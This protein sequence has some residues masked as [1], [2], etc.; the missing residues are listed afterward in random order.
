MDLFA[1]VSAIFNFIVYLVYDR[2]YDGNAV[3]DGAVCVIFEGTA[4]TGL[5]VKV[6]FH[7]PSSRAEFTGR[8]HGPS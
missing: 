8:V 6:G 4:L 5:K 3:V 1:S 7:Y 2:N